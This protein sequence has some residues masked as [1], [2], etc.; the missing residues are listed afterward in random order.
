M[1]TIILQ[2][3]KN[4]AIRRNAS[5]EIIYGDDKCPV[6]DEAEFTY[7]DTYTMPNGDVII[8]PTGFILDFADEKGMEVYVGLINDEKFVEWGQWDNP[9]CLNLPRQIED[10]KRFAEVIWG[11]Y[12]KKPGASEPRPSFKGWYLP[13]EM[14]N[15]AYTE[16]QI[17]DFRRF[18]GAVSKRCKEL[19]GGLPVTVSPFFNPKMLGAEAFAETYGRFLRKGQETAGIDIVM[20]QDSVGAKAIPFNDISTVV[21]EYYR[22]MRGKLDELGIKFWANVES[23]GCEP[24]RPTEIMRLTRQLETARGHVA[25]GEKIVTFDFYHYMNPFG[26]DHV[27]DE[28]YVA[29]E[30]SLYCEYLKRHVTGAAPPLGV[31]CSH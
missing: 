17:R 11:R 3:L 22:A 10:N 12:G 1:K 29:A 5:G 26:Y 13:Q 15:Q 9:R 25:A 27:I 8:D 30:R 14:W 18:F 31:E 19:S 20:L 7:T 2:Y 23:F 16:D 28:S 21:G 6:M 24:R 4:R